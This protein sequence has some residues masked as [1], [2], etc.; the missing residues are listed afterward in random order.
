MTVMNT[1][2][3]TLEEA[4]GEPINVTTNN[5]KKSE[6]CELYDNRNRQ[7]NKPH[8]NNTKRELEK[9]FYML[10]HQKRSNNDDYEQYYGYADARA[11]SR[12]SNTLPKH[13]ETYKNKSSKQIN[14]DSK[15]NTYSDSTNNQKKSFDEDDDNY[16]T[17]NQK[18]A[19]KNISKYIDEEIYDEDMDIESEQKEYNNNNRK[20]YNNTNQMIDLSIYTISGILLIFIMEQ[21]V[22]VGMKI[23]SYS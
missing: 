2:F 14:I 7:K 21:F 6:Q 4:W 15:T 17:S 20:T 9:D 11:H 3:S 16:L 23:K 10:N 19:N 22:Q 8:R 13:K 1:Q 18:I 12:T 5:I